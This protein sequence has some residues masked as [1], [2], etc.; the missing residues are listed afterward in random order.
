MKILVIGG[1]GNFGKRLVN[2]L[3][4]HHDHE[5]TVAGRSLHEAEA[6]Y[7]S[8]L[9]SSG[10][11]ITTA[12]IDVFD[13]DLET[14][15]WQQQA[16]IVVNASG[17]YQVQAGDNQ[18]PLARACA[19]VGSHY[20]DL[21]DDRRFVR[22]FAA[23]LDQLAKQKGVTLVTGASTVPGLSAAV[24]D[25][26]DPDFARLETIDYG[27]SPGNRTERGEATV[28][29]ILSY[30]GLDFDTLIEGRRQK[31]IGWQNLRRVDLGPPLQR[32]WM[33]NCDIPDLDLLPARYPTLKTVRF[34]AGLEVTVL[35][36]G[37]WVLSLFSRIGIV[38]NWA[39]FTTP[40]T[41]MSDWFKSLGSECGGMFVDMTGV[42][43]AGVKRRISWQLVAENG[44]GP[45][46]PT[47][48]A[49]LMV[50]RITRGDCPAGAMPCI[51]LFGLDE[52]LTI[53]RRWGIYVKVIDHV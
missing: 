44:S 5:V 6:F 24:L 17:P 32:R 19:N 1:Y 29:S 50:E 48:S 49:E 46:V 28:A 40:L 31:V 2:S 13:P 21:A 34:Q 33:G 43:A 8:C 18:Y 20:I 36:L 42:D 27:I 22:G 38:E 26:F 9:E 51:G 14:L 11:T 3:L 37:L 23:S 39:K 53:A 15:I 35:H 41:R 30:T 4:N 7:Q 16:D 10:K 25:H 52:F 45:Y 47:I 12:R